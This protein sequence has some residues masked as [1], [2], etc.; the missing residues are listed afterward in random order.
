V[1]AERQRRFRSPGNDRVSGRETVTATVSYDS[2]EDNGVFAALAE[3]MGAIAP[4]STSL[5]LN[6]VGGGG[7]SALNG[8]EYV[9]Y[10]NFPIIAHKGER[11][12]TAGE[13]TGLMGEV[14]ALR[15]D[16]NSLRKDLNSIGIALLQ[17][18]NKT[19]RAI[20]GFTIDGAPA[21]RVSVQ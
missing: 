4:A 5:N 13:V 8:L 20:D 19:G 11:V 2:T 7:F 14:K 3:H 10:D 16:L 17:R 9:P 6:I 1:D 18:A 15:E 12:Q 21:V